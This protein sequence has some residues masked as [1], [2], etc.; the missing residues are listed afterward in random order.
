MIAS[1]LCGSKQQIIRLFYSFDDKAIQKKCKRN[2]VSLPLGAKMI[3][4]ARFSDSSSKQ[5]RAKAPD[6]IPGA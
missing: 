1:G 6:N 2:V 4:A 3:T 5:D